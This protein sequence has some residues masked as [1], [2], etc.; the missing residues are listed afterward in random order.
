MEQFYTFTLF[1]SIPVTIAVDDNNIYKIDNIH[2]SFATIT[3]D[4]PSILIQAMGDEN[5]QSLLIESISECGKKKD[6]YTI[7]ARNEYEYDIY[8]TLQKKEN[9]KKEIAFHHSDQDTSIVVTKG[10]TYECCY[11]DHMIP[12]GYSYFDPCDD[13]NCNFVGNFYYLICTK[14]HYTFVIVMDT[15]TK[16]IVYQDVVDEYQFSS[17]TITLLHAMD[18]YYHHAR[19]T[20][21]TN[22]HMDEY[23]VFTDRKVDQ[24]KEET[25]I[26]LVFL[27]CIACSDY[28]HAMQYLSGDLKPT[29][30]HLKQYFGGIDEIYYAGNE[31][32]KIDYV[33]RLGNTFKKHHFT[34]QA[35]KI[36]N[37][38]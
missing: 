28:T 6:D 14:P 12:C 29:P 32:E 3:S 31:K 34:L 33:V 13:F 10:V 36:S 11:Y 4:K 30:E 16:K 26:P 35:G 24:V 5:S 20:K 18:D 27:E 22:G 38:D 15:K 8:L 17:D 7:I 25:L 19:V 21:F 37:I 23:Y 2:T 1:S 9:S